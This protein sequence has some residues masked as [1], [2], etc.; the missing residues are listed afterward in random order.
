[1]VLAL[2]APSALAG[3]ASSPVEGQSG[4]GPPVVAPDGHHV[5]LTRWDRAGLWVLNGGGVGRR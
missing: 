1:M 2:L 5:A 4:F 3:G